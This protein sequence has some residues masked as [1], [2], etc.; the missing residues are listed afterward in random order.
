MQKNS[1]KPEPPEPGL[2][3]NFD[4]PKFTARTPVTTTVEQQELGDEVGKFLY[5]KQQPT[6]QDIER[7]LTPWQAVCQRTQALMTK[8]VQAI[9]GVQTSEIDFWV[10]NILDDKTAQ[11]GEEKYS[12][13]HYYPSHQYQYQ[14][15]HQTR[16]ENRKRNTG[17]LIGTS[18]RAIGNRFTQLDDPQ[19]KGGRENAFR[20][21]VK[22]KLDQCKL[23]QF[24]CKFNQFTSRQSSRV[25]HVGNTINCQ[26]R[27][28]EQLCD[29][30]HQ[31][32]V[33]NPA[34]GPE[35]SQ[36]EKILLVSTISSLKTNNE[37]NVKL[38]HELDFRSELGNTNYNI[39]QQYATFK[40]KTARTTST[41]TETNRTIYINKR[42]ETIDNDFPFCIE[43]RIRNIR[44]I[45][46]ND[47][48]NH[49]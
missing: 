37:I 31:F 14:R 28:C 4:P 15:K 35:K 5:S 11:P 39:T 1:E 26:K 30:N 42:S 16:S 43:R 12:V 36:N 27:C 20:K 10:M 3:V 24:G 44:N 9:T 48:R 6:L 33:W 19:L 2:F 13:L 47:K 25:T 21:I 40:L 17:T 34:A 7:Q 46:C 41:R 45:K 32:T 38:E 22:R 23:F 8:V 49:Q 29:R 18:T